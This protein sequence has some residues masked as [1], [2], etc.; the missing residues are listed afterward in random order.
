MSLGI[1]IFWIVVVAI[2]AYATG[3]VCC[4]YKEK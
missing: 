1:V 4:K 3:Y 2:V